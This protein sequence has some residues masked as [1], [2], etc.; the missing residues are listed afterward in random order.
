MV[1][2]QFYSVPEVIIIEQ[3]MK[4]MIFTNHIR[5]R[6]IGFSDS[7]NSWKNKFANPEVSSCLVFTNLFVTTMFLVSMGID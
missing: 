7:L 4:A 2:S 3:N 6:D 5:T 1:I